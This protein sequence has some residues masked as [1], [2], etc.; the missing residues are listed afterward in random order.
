M[1]EQ[2]SMMTQLLRNDEKRKTGGVW[3]KTLVTNA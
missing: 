3:C 1:R 2:L